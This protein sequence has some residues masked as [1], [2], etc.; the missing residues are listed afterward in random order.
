MSYS[1][2]YASA[3]SAAT[4][5]VFAPPVSPNASADACAIISTVAAEATSPD[6]ASPCI[7]ITSPKFASEF[8]PAGRPIYFRTL[9]TDDYRG[10]GMAR[11]LTKTLGAKTGYVLD[12]S[13]FTNAVTRER[14]A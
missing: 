3:T 11:F 9:T 12:D 7:G 6:G 1:K 4:N 5:S 2:A 8:R 14:G 13:V 10:P